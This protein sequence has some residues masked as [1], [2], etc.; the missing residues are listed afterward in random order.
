MLLIL[1]W[2]A[3]VYVSLI[4]KQPKLSVANGNGFLALLVIMNGFLLLSTS[5]RR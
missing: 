2:L 4:A 5:V 3:G 1:P